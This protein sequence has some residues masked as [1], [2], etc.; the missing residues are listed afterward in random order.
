MDR[1]LDDW[2]EWNAKAEGLVAPA[3]SG[4]TEGMSPSL[5][6]QIEAVMAAQNA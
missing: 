1:V 5:I 3:E 6:S 4:K 2:R